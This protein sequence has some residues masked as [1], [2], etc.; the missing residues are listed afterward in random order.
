[1]TRRHLILLSSTVLILV[2]LVQSPICVAGQFHSSSYGYTI[3]VPQ[4]WVQ[5]P[6]KVLQEMVRALQK[7]KGSAVVIYDTG[8]QLDSANRWFEYPYVLIQAYGNA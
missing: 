3:D 2:A 1:M 6:Q 7:Q 5:I 4:G 8:F